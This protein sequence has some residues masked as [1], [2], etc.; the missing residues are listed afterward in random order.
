MQ[1]RQLGLRGRRRDEVQAAQDEDFGRAG[2]HYDDEELM[3]RLGLRLRG[4]KRQW[5]RIGTV[6]LGLSRADVEVSAIPAQSWRFTVHQYGAEQPLVIST[7]TGLFTGF[8]PFVE[9]LMSGQPLDVVRRAA[10]LVLGEE[11][12]GA[13]E[14]PGR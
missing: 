6:R 13:D 11:T 7:G 14:E 12:F 5:T 2:A 10:D 8:W 1:L 4:Y 3:R 9:M